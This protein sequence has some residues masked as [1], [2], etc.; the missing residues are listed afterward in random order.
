MLRRNAEQNEND[1][2]GSEADLRAGAFYTLLE[3]TLT[4]L[5]HLLSSALC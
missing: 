3:F 4:E 5:S 1:Y 2:S